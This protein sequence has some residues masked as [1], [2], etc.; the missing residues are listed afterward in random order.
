MSDLRRGEDISQAVAL[1][2]AE[3]AVKMLENTK[4]KQLIEMEAKEAEKERVDIELMQ[5]QDRVKKI[6]W[7][8]EDKKKEAGEI[9]KRMDLD[10]LRPENQG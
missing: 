6:D 2:Q 8:I 1:K 3:F 9:Q 7:Q 5:M 10:K 4:K